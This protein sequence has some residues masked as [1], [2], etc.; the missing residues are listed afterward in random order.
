MWVISSVLEPCALPFACFVLC[1]SVVFGSLLSCHEFRFRD[2]VRTLAL[3]VLSCCVSV[4]SRVYSATHS[5]VL[6]CCWT[7]FVFLSAVC[8]HVMS[9]SVWYAAC[10]C[11]WVFSLAACS[12]PVLHM[13]G[14]FV[15]LAMCLCF[16]FVWAHVF[17]LSFLCALMSIVLTLP[18]LLPDYWLICH[19]GASFV[20]FSFAPYLFSLWIF[21]HVFEKFW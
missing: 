2:K 9:C 16:C 6:V 12:C 19:T 4:R 14:D 7:Q 5:S 3:H 13:A 18:I 21:S 10:V 17:C 11:H 15:F 8:I 1:W 20:T